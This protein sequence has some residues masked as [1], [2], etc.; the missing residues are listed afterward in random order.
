M[1]L[2]NRTHAVWLESLVMLIPHNSTVVMQ[3]EYM[4]INHYTELYINPNIL[5][6]II[7]QD[8]GFDMRIYL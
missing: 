3:M 5:F 1:R 8:I 2:Y 6:G 4:T 7:Q